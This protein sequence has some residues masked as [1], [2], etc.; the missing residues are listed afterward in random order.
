MAKTLNVGYTDTA[1]SPD[2]GTLNL[3]R[4]KINFVKDFRVKEN[5]E[6]EMILTNLTSP[7]DRPE[8][9]RVGYSRVK[10]VYVNSQIDPSVYSP[11]KAGVSILT[12]LSE[13]FSVTD[14]VDPSYRVDLPVKAHLVI[15]VPNSADITVN[16]VETLV[17]RLV[18]TL[19]DT[20]KTDTTRLS[21]ILRGALMPQ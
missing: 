9:L 4:A 8:T 13:T 6:N 14:T 10:D 19:Y 20:G 5:K 3:V 17:G 18:S 1:L 12:Q 2:P 15:T 16:M 7:F 21:Q 11:S